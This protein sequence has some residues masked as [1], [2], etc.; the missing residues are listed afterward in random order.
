NVRVLKWI[1]ERVEGKGQAVETPIGWVPPPGALTL[2]GL[3]ITHNTMEELLRV[4]PDDWAPELEET[5]KFFAQF[6]KRLPQELRE[7]HA[8]LAQRFERRAVAQK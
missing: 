4:N 2:D 5:K 1:L 7:E 3:E 6:G 8:R